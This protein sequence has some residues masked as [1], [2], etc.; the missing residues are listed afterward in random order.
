MITPRITRLIRT[1]HLHAFQRAIASTA[2]H[3]EVG[4]TRACAVIVPSRAAAAELRR[5]IEHLIRSDALVLPHILTRDEWYERLHEALGSVPPRLTHFERTVL[6][7]AAAREATAS[8]HEPPFRLRPGLIDQILSLY[9]ALRR[10]RQTLDVFERLLI[11]E[12]EPQA[13]ADR[14]A[15]RMLRQTRFLAAA[16]RAYERRAAESG[17]IDEHRLRELVLQSPANPEFR[18]L[19]VTLGD[20]IAEPGGLWI[21]DFDLLARLP[22][23]ER[24]DVVVTENLLATG[25]HERLH[26]LLPGIEEVALQDGSLRPPSLVAP[27]DDS[28]AHYFTSRDREEEL[29]SIAR[30]LNDERRRGASTDAP[31]LDRVAIV[32]RRPLPYVYLARTVFGSAGIPFQAFDALPLA[33]EPFAAAVD[34]VLTFVVSGFTRASAIALLQSPFFTFEADGKP[35]SAR[36]VSAL[37]RLLGDMGYL[38]DRALLSRLAETWTGPDARGRHRLAAAAAHAAASAADELEP[39]T[40]RDRPSAHLERLASFIGVHERHIRFDDPLRERH[41]RARAAI[42]G[43]LASLHDAHEKHDDEPCT[44]DALA[45][46]IR[47]W[48]EE[49]TF[50]PRTGATGV[51]LVDAQAAPYGD[52]DAIH[53][54]GLI[55]GEWPERPPRN[56]FYSPWLLA[57]L[58]WAADAEPLPAARAAFRDLLGL[59]ASRVSLSTFT[60]EDEGIVSPSSLL[61]LDDVERAGLSI[62]RV[63]QPARARIFA[64]E[65]LSED[66]VLVD[67][68][69]PAA[70]RWARL[71]IARTSADRPWFRGQAGPHRQP[72]YSVSALERYLEC[73][74][75]FFA[76]HVLKLEEE[77][78]DEQTMSPRKRGKF[79]HEIFQA[80]FR[81]WE[82]LGRG[83]ITREDLDE[84]RDVFSRV[85]EPLLARLPENEAALERTRLLGSPAA[86]GLA[87]IVFRLEAEW[88]VEAAERLLEFEIDGDLEVAGEH[89]TRRVNLSGIVDRIDLLADGTLRVIDY[90]SGR[91]PDPKRALQLPIYSLA[92]RERLRGYG[93]RDWALGEAAYISFGGPR[94]LTPLVGRGGDRDKVLADAQA[95]LLR[96]VDGIERGEFPVDPEDPFRCTFCAYSGVCRKDYVGDT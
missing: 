35:L 4:A 57:K 34:L 67:A 42:M 82:A 83:S 8:G 12:L 28:G 27:R 15:D 46:R 44:I 66:P 48:I 5:T 56:I 87:E 79:L 45:P 60:L 53:I 64:H 93:G 25:L 19:V 77:P 96:A 59:A 2:C 7:G 37:D 26:D 1:P 16:F 40:T 30:R 49:Q 55:E 36:A 23:L 38:G 31:P 72:V 54:V 10:Q 51:H 22:R 95:R 11:E 86:V 21:A 20:R 52:F 69:D 62:V 43:A 47:R 78:E 91:A 94:S 50:S 71:R 68:A 84:A 76:A 61:E 92:A 75:K 29:T 65:A 70:A 63:D 13:E 58:G 39:L 88:P 24:L 9:D 90:K 41:V 18:H 89:G 6:F 3:P 73:P 80:F 17:A 74:F 14:G 85:I 32:M 81:E 33:A